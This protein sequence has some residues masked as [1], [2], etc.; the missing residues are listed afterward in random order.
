MWEELF[1]QTE[2]ARLLSAPRCCL[3]SS[4]PSLFTIFSLVKTTVISLGIPVN[5]PV[6]ET[7]GTTDINNV[8]WKPVTMLFTHMKMNRGPTVSLISRPNREAGCV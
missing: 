2:Q 6:P 3:G 5:P 7:T 8:P 4:L 1:V